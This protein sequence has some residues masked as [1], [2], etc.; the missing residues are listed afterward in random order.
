MHDKLLTI[1]LIMDLY[2][3]QIVSY[4]LYTHQKI[5]LVADTL[6]EALEVRGNPKGVIIHSD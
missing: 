6:K 5:P 3:N 4:K 2:N 1:F